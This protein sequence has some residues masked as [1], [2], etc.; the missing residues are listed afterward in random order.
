[1]NLSEKKAHRLVAVWKDA[2]SLKEAVD[3]AGLSNKDERNNRRYRRLAEQ[4]T[5]QELPPHNP[6]FSTHTDIQCPSTLD[7]DKAKNNSSFIVT[8]C[9]NNSKLEI[10]FLQAL[11]NFVEH[12]AGCQLLIVPVRYKNLSAMEH[13]E[14][15]EWPSQIYKYAL[16][17]DLHLN[18]SLVVSGLRLQATAVN[19]L[20]GLHANSGVKSAIYG[21]PQL[22]MELVPTPKSE[23]PK[24]MHT[25]GAL[26]KPSYSS[27]KAGGKATFHHSIS[28][29]YVKIVGDKFYPIQLCWDGQGFYYL[30][31]YWT[32]YGVTSD[33]SC[34]AI[35]LKDL[36]EK[37][38]DD[39]IT[40]ATENLKKKVNPTTL[41]WHDIYDHYSQSYHHD[42]MTR[43]KIARDH[44][45]LVGDEVRSCISFI[46]RYGEGYKN[47]IVES[48]HHDH[49]DK[50]VCEYNPKHDPH[51]AE[52][53]SQVFN[54]MINSETSALQSSFDHYAGDDVDYEFISPNEPYWIESIDVSQHGHRGTNGTKGTPR[55]FARTH[56]KTVIG[57]KHTPQIEKGCWTVGV[58]NTDLEYA[59]GL[60][61]WLSADCI[62]YKNGKRALVFYIDDKSLVDF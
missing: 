60:S 36:H 4:I 24:M 62:I 3:L 57:D 40:Q 43:I 45:H 2:S 55:G 28:A 7:L 52:F 9:C 26:N 10:E 27:T 31:E 12:N 41:I 47:V 39:Y 35:V 6:K 20:S 32:K 33:N 18:D 16:L 42:L 30:D 49:L 25:T 19:P 58:W 17:E 37:H 23:L 50:W 56:H 29:V 22:A 38:A 48:N 61:S 14:G 34:S 15:Y 51:N 54:Q 5:G 13:N 53:Y 21:H 46:Q 1:M 59:K 11:E 8:S 44:D